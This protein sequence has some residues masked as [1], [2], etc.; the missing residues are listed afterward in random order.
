VGTDERDGVLVDPLTRFGRRA[1]L[2]MGAAGAL[3]AAHLAA[4]GTAPTNGRAHALILLWLGGGPSQ[5]ETFDPKPGKAIGGPT[6]AIATSTAGVQI[7]AGLPLVA[8]EMQHLALVRSLVGKEGDHERA[9]VLMKTGRRPEVAL[10]HPSLGAVLAHELDEAT[11]IPRYVALL[12]FDRTSRGGWLGPAWDPFRVADPSAPLE[13]VVA[14]VSEEREARRLE[15]LEVL[16]RHYAEGNPHAAPRTT[17]PERTER[18][19]R[20]MRSPD[21]AAFRLDDEPAAVRAAYGATPFGR[22]CL[23]ARRLVEAGVRC[24][25]V[26]LGGWD[27]HI[28]NFTATTE[29]TAELDGAFAALVRDLRERDLW[30]STVV[31]CTGEF[32]RTPII[33]AADGRDHWPTGFSCVLGGAGIR[34]GVVVGET[35][36]GSEPPKTPIAPAEICAT[37]LRALGVDPA[38]EHQTP[39][40]RPVKL[41]DAAPIAE[42][43]AQA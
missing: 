9:S 42:L 43:A 41:A 39:G 26:S 13:D 19:L 8:A 23:V 25:E 17:H 35:S 40:G 22:G 28:D 18:A 34:G 7:A 6:R 14:A 33:N 10:T 32:G 36:E 24:V 5:L 11:D 1:F 4:R 20:T 27:T 15:D 29:L 16:E 37:V 30:R 12:G 21:L 31:L 3:V 38:T 2:G